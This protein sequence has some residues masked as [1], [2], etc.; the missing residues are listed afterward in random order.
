[1]LRPIPSVLVS[2]LVAWPL[3]GMAQLRMPEPVAEDIVQALRA[4]LVEAVE[5]LADNDTAGAARRFDTLIDAPGFAVLDADERYSALLRAGIAAL[6]LGQESKAHPLLVRACGFNE[7]TGSAWHLRLQAAYAI[8]DFSDSALAIGVIARRWPQTLGQIREQ[9]IFNV[10]RRTKAD[11]AAA[12][13]HASLLSDL[14][15][16][17]WTDEGREPDPLWTD[18]ARLLLE[19]RDLARATEVAARIESAEFVHGLR[20]DRRFD[21]LVKA[22]RGGFD[23]ARAIERE[24]ARNRHLREAAADR[25]E[26]LVHEIMLDLRDGDAARG[27]ALADETLARIAADGMSAYADAD[28]EYVWL[29]DVRAQALQRLGRWDEAVAQLRRAARRPEG[30]AMNVSQ[31]LNLGRLLARLERVDE[32]EPAMEDVGSMSAY[33]RLQFALNRL[34]AALVRGDDAAVEVQLDELRRGR[35]E[36]IG[37]WQAALVQAGRIDAAAAVLIERL[38]R[39]DWRRDALS[40]MQECVRTLEAPRD[41]LHMRNWQA[42]LERRDVRKALDAVGRI[43]RVPFA[44]SPL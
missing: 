37:T 9:A 8:D 34:I 14:Y 7:A 17:N 38:A 35:A 29:L 24:R 1:M 42:V 26:P 5:H 30:G 41:T 10:V 33:G 25:L 36:S 23:V 15:D 6:E 2:I 44:C 43:E 22:R 3:A 4:Q 11:P 20:V 12:D 40:E 31:V 28:E 18:Y 13:R 32:L 19:R 16:A 21:A 27:L 39:E